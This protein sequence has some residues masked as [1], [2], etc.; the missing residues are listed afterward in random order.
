MTRPSCR[1][2]RA[3]EVRLWLSVIVFITWGFMAAAGAADSCRH[4]IAVRSAAAVGEIPADESSNSCTLLVVLAESH[5]RR[6][7]F[8]G[9]LRKIT[10]QPSRARRAANRPKGNPD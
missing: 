6:Q 2:F 7:L 4:L 8:A 1:C 10:L 9:M 5:L 3:N